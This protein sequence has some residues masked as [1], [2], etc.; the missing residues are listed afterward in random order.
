MENDMRK[1]LTKL[2]Q[3]GGLETYS[4]QYYSADVEA[5]WTFDD[6]GPGDPSLQV[7]YNRNTSVNGKDHKEDYWLYFSPQDA[8]AVGAMLRAWAAMHGEKL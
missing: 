7:V 2:I 6:E 4:I 3:A 1:Q 8:A 5:Q